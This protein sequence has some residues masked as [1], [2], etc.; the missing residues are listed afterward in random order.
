[1]EVTIWVKQCPYNFSVVCGQVVAP[2]PHIW[3]KYR[4]HLN[5][6]GLYFQGRQNE[7]ADNHVF[8]YLADSYTK[9]PS[10]CWQ[11]SCLGHPINLQR[12]Q[13]E[14]EATSKTAVQA[15]SFLWLYLLVTFC[16]V[17]LIYPSHSMSLVH[18]TTS[19]SMNKLF[20]I[21]YHIT[22]SIYY[23]II[24][25]IIEIQKKIKHYNVPIDL[26]LS[27]SSSWEI[28]RN[29]K[30]HHSPARGLWY[31]SWFWSLMAFIFLT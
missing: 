26:L 27:I 24:I 2:P 6:H 25:R 23:V 4:G 15:Q 1:M 19:H 18:W 31:M 30:Y 22:G 17:R 20:N 8:L 16:F 9:C 28:Q 3:L 21:V 13:M 29:T 12:S 14:V 10:Y 5:L 11:F 7:L